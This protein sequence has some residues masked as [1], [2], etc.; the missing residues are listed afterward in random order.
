MKK[1]LIYA[2]SYF[3]YAKNRFPHL[4]KQRFLAIALAILLLLMV[5]TVANFST[6]G[7]WLYP[8]KVNFLEKIESVLLFSRYSQSERI[9]ALSGDRLSEAGQLLTKSELSKDKEVLLR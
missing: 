2:Q 5:L 8:I 4:F 9:R 1:I 3:A 7:S 6:P